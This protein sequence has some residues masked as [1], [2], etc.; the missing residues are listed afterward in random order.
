MRLTGLS[1]P[2]ALRPVPCAIFLC[3]SPQHCLLSLEP[4]AL[5]PKPLFLVEI[6]TSFLS[7][8]VQSNY[9]TSPEPLNVEGL[10]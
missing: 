3:F 7:L 8:F 6:L 2:C 10:T 1:V 9:F 5:G 4:C